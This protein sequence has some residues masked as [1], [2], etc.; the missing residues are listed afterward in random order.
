MRATETITRM[1]RHI[2]NA[3]NLKNKDLTDQTTY[4]ALAMECFQAVNAAIALANQLITE[5]NLGFPATYKEIFEI[6]NQQKIIGEEELKKTKRLV[7]LRNLIAHEYYRI[8]AEELREMA[9]LLTTLEKTAE[10]I[11][12]HIKEK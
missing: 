4:S 1:E 5:E 12:K 2:K 6:L 7:F 10:K 9:E 11:K 3:R 8:K